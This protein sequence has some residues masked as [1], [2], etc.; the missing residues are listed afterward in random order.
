MKHNEKP[1][2]SHMKKFGCKALCH[3][4]KSPRMNSDDKVT[5]II[6]VGYSIESK[7]YRLMN[8]ATFKITEAWDVVFIESQKCNL[9]NESQNDPKIELDEDL[10]FPVHLL[11]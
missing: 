11:P 5:E 7:G 1:D 9:T 3:I 10:L 6:F 8:P 2:L 4:P